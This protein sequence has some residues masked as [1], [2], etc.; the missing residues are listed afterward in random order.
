MTD[1]A[2]RHLAKRLAAFEDAADRSDWDDVR[3]RASA[4]PR[5]ARRRSVAGAA[6]AVAALILV[7]AGMGGRIVG[8]FTKHGKPVPE[9]S[10]AN[11]DRELLISFCQDVYLSTAPGRVPQRRCRGGFPKAEEI[12][13]DGRRLYLKITYRD[14]RTCLASGRVRPYRD[15]LRGSGRVGSLS[16]TQEP[17]GLGRLVPSPRR[18][19]TTEVSG[20]FSP[21]GQA[22]FVRV[23]G[24]AGNGV[25]RVRLLGKRGKSLDAP[26]RGRIYAFE[27]LPPGDWVAIA[28]LNGDGHEVYR[29]KLHLPTVRPGLRDRRP[30]AGLK[31]RRRPAPSSAR[32]TPPPL[33]PSR[34]FQHGGQSGAS[35][36]VYRTGLVA[37]DIPPASGRAYRLLEHSWVSLGCARVAYGAGRWATLGGGRSNIF[38]SEHLRAMV[39]GGIRFGG[40]VPPPYDACSVRGTYGWRWGSKRGWHDAVEIGL[41]PLGHRFLDEK[42]AA[43]ELAYFVRSPT[44][45]RARDAMK[46]G[47][48]APR[49]AA[50]A[51]H[52]G[53]RVVVLQRPGDLPPPERI[54][55][56]SDR[57]ARL[58]AS[59]RTPG[60]RRLFVELDHGRIGRY[61]LRELAFVF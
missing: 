34:P 53:S 28:A 43:R 59:I 58:V 56:W 25:E 14:G 19:I 29:E 32:T 13:N 60:G 31:L 49:G 23:E 8:A 22:S 9:R 30:P 50:I 54:G 6:L 12:A 45:T 55:I 16:C 57:G 3:R 26:V 39:G 17:G 4:D 61:N 27:K 36:D 2:D 20:A 11:L 47:A 5:R 21:K 37:F 10:L 35:V 51:R 38:F 44:M 48:M 1:A 15:R 18:P 41:T 52:Y 7:A 33:P 46:H 42:A 24:L 40:A